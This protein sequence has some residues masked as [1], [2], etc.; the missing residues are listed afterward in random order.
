M[1]I[2]GITETNGGTLQKPVT[3]TGREKAWFDNDI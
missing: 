1:Q 3:S 2:T